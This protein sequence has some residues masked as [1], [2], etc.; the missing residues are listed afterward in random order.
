VAAIEEGE[1]FSLEKWKKILFK[2]SS[3]PVSE[4][5]VLCIQKFPLFSVCTSNRFARGFPFLEAV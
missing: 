1:K 2:P 3:L 5:A 4:R